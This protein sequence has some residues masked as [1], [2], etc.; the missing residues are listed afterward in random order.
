MD[1]LNFK[2]LTERHLQI[3]LGEGTFATNFSQK[4]FPIQILMGILRNVR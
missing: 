4:N 1:G 3:P 2:T